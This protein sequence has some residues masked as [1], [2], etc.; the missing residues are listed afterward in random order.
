MSL[1]PHSRTSTSASRWRT[2][3]GELQV[4][5]N[6]QVCSWSLKRWHMSSQQSSPGCLCRGCVGLYFRAKAALSTSVHRAAN[7]QCL[8][9]KLYVATMSVSRALTESRIASSDQDRA[10]GRCRPASPGCNVLLCI[11]NLS[12]TPVAQKVNY[13]AA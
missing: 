1:F 4:C 8:W 10:Q 2:L 3:K 9:P 13:T 6:S 11:S 7:E 12:M 5:C